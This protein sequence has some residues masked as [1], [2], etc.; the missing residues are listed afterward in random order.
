MSNRMGTYVR[1][2]YQYN[3]HAVYLYASKTWGNAFLYFDFT[4]DGKTFWVIGPKVG[5]NSVNI[6]ALTTRHYPNKVTHDWMVADAA[7]NRFVVAMSIEV[8]CG[9]AVE[10]P[11][12][13]ECED[14][15]LAGQKKGHSM[16]HRMGK[17]LL[18]AEKYNDRLCTAT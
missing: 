15:V 3:S 6:Y 7:N 1:Q 4:P 5:S 11:H 14:I 17:Y 18:Q 2:P 12:L 8:D 10:K 13:G 16:Y 9:L